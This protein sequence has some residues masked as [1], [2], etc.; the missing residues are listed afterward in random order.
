MSRDD[1]GDHGAAR[2]ARLFVALP[3]AEPVRAALDPVVTPL[4]GRAD[5]LSW[6]DPDGWHLTLAFLG[7]VELSLVDQ[8]EPALRG[9][10]IDQGPIELRLGAA[11]RFGPRVLWI[12]VEDDPPGALEELG[13]RLQVSIATAGLPVERRAVRPHLTLARGGRGRAVRD[14]HLDEL[15]DALAAGATG[16]AARR[17]TADEV[18]VWRTEL[19]RG[20]AR[21]HTVARVSLEG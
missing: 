3:V 11:G 1:G 14:R 7:R 18:Q 4:R 10:V 2:S 15:T 17:W 6:T 12:A 20:P 9:A 13:E 21:Y 8:L 19:R 16:D 5:E